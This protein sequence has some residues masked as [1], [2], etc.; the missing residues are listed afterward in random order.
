MGARLWEVREMSNEF[1][2]DQSGFSTSGGFVQNTGGYGGDTAGGFQQMPAG[3]SAGGAW[4][5]N[6]GYGAGADHADFEGEP[7]ILEEL[8]INFDHIKRKTISVLHPTKSLDPDLLDDCDMAGPIAY[9]L[10][11]GATL[12]LRMKLNF[13]FIYGISFTGTV[14]LWL[15]LN[16]MSLTGIDIYRTTSVLGYCLLPMV[17]F[18][19]AAVLLSM[20]GIIGGVLGC[21][22][23]AWCTY[24]SADMFIAILQDP[25]LTWLVRYPVCLLYTC[26]ALI[27]VF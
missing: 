22:T 16:L 18:S 17:F 23:I 10:M 3:Q 27:V 8:G 21:I 1:V 2:Q 5:G 19:G 26:F 9:C 4:E 6:S 24:S 15:L 13:G 11:L 12:L 25:D 20:Q 7:P 14:A